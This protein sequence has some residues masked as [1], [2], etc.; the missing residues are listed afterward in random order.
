MVTLKLEQADAIV[1]L[2]GSEDY[3][4]R[5]AEAARLYK[6]GVSGRVL[7]TN[8]GVKGGWNSELQRNPF[9]VERA[10]WALIENSVPVEAIEIVPGTVKGDSSTGTENEADAVI[11]YCID[12]ETKSVLIV[13]SAYHTRRALFIYRT[14]IDD[15]RLEFGISHPKP[16]SFDVPNPLWWLSPKSWY[17]IVSEYVKMPFT[18]TFWKVSVA[19]LIYVVFASFPLE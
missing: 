1:V 15:R 10:R 19:I 7:L 8:D 17:H 3:L 2:A 12:S 18:Q 13:T 11:R 16:A 9:F 14:A 5:T 4:E 6:T